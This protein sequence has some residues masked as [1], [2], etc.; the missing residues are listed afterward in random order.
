[1]DDVIQSL[2]VENA[3][4]VVD[5]YHLLRNEFAFQHSR[6]SRFVV[7]HVL[8]RKRRFKDLRLVLDQMLQE[9]GGFFTYRINVRKL[10]LW[11]LDLKSFF[12]YETNEFVK[13]N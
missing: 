2:S 8:A 7:S 1:M 5:F 13:V 10:S 6:G 9:E 11:L 4:F 12:F 3:D